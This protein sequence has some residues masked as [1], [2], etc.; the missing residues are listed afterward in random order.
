[1]ARDGEHSQKPLSDFQD[2]LAVR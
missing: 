1:M 2:T